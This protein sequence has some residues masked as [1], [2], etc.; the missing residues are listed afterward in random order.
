M[1]EH[2]TLKKFRLEVTCSI[3]LEYFSD[4]VILECGHNFCHHCLVKYWKEFVTNNIC[5]QCKVATESKGLINKPLEKFVRMLQQLNDE[6]E[7]KGVCEKH[8]EP[9]KCFCKN[10][11]AAICMK[12]AESTEH[13]GHNT[14]SLEE[15]AQ[16]LKDY[17]REFLDYLNNQQSAILE[18]KTRTET[19]SLNLLK[20]TEKIKKEIDLEFE[21][22][23]HFLKNEEYFLMTKIHQIEKEIR[24]KRDERMNQL[25]QEHTS[26][27]R[28]VRELQKKRDQQANDLLQQAVI[29]LDK[30]TAHPHLNVSADCKSVKLGNEA[31][32]LPKNRK[33]FDS[34]L[35]VLG[36]EEF[37]EGRNYWDVSVENEGE[38]TV[39]VARKSVRRKDPIFIGPKNGIWAIGKRG[40]EYFVLDPPNSVRLQ[41]NGELKRIRVF[42]NYYGKHVA[43]FDAEG[44]GMLHRTF[45]TM[46]SKEIFLPF[47]HLS[48]TAVLTL[49]P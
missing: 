22:L 40:N 8:Q 11:Q 36:C 17:F 25:F 24:E 9:W 21:E 42:F 19:E 18:H 35:S 2:N 31:Q 41:H 26:H 37:T 10:H 4:P 45:T 29:T 32:N 3:C 47:F 39:G 7:K 23:R 46:A 13:E 30:E 38:W 6:P 16:E 34:S 20:L 49:T 28:L 33:R 43:F 12:C 1:S 5:P 48:D 27:D 44:A 15:A 14:I